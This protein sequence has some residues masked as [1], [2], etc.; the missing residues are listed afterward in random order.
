[1]KTLG[2]VG[3]IGPES[4]VEYYRLLIAGYRE[5]VS[6]GSY[7]PLLIASIDVKKLLA[8]VAQGK[9]LEL[10]EYLLGSLRQ[11]ERAGADFAI[12][13]GNTP[14]IVFDEVES[15]SPLPLS[16]ILQASC[17]FA[18]AQR[19]KRLGLF[20]TCSTMQAGFYQK[21]F[22]RAGI[23]VTIPESEEQDYIH[24]K[25][26]SELVNGVFLAETRQRLFGIANTLKQRHNID[27]L[28]LGGTELP[29]ILRDGSGVCVPL[30]DT[31][32]I[33]VNAALERL[34]SWRPV[35]G[36]DRSTFANDCFA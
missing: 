35:R 18:R 34:L 27:G 3:G 30:L 33:H 7:P 11:L 22:G 10:V 8:L 2:I 14:H 31:T 36:W 32:R 25:Y 20:G 15:R 13:A 19:L 12:L 6:D 28:I 26:V 16:S 23:A 4:T 5:R 17:N 21:I 29:L 9:L 24:E 1:M